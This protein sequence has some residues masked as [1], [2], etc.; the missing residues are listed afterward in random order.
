VIADS[1][2]NSVVAEAL[3]KYAVGE[4]IRHT[5][6]VSHSVEKYVQSLVCP[7]CFT[8]ALKKVAH[9]DDIDSQACLEELAE[10]GQR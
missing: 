6:Q 3:Q 5:A 1:N 9:D 4:S 2:A 7:F 10:E 8:K